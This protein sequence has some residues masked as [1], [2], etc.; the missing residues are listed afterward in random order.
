MSESRGRKMN[1]DLSE[2]R[3]LFLMEAS[4][5]NGGMVESCSRKKDRNGR[6]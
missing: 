5:V 2:N 3:K 4:E 6:G 1:Q